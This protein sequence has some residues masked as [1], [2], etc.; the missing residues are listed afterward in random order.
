MGPNDV[1]TI[2][3]H[4][5]EQV[6]G[7]TISATSAAAPSKAKKDYEKGLDQAK[8]GKFEEAQHKFES[9]VAALSELRS[10]VG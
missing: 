2:T 8:K 7:F 3:L 5:M 10:G 6:E 9:A 4:R 1:G